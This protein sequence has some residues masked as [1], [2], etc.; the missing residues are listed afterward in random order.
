MLSSDRND[1]GRYA[2]RLTLFIDSN[3]RRL[4]RKNEKK[5]NWFCVKY[6]VA[7]NAILPFLPFFISKAVT[8]EFQL[9]RFYRRLFVLSQQD[10]HYYFWFSNIYFIAHK[11]I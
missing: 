2:R 8:S 11:S 4:L 7:K 5:Y 3:M 1:P 9:F 6:S 10:T